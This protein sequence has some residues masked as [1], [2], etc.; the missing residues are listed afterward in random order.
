MECLMHQ[1]PPNVLCSLFLIVTLGRYYSYPTA[2]HKKADGE[3][4][5][6]QAREHH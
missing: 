1:E 5:A 4:G 2:G 6:D 3:C